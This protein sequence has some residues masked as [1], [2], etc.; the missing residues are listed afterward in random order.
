MATKT[1]NR[2]SKSDNNGNKSRSSSERSA[3]NFGDNN[4]GIL[5]GAAAAGAAL[6]FA[7][8]MGRK[9]LMQ[10]M[11]G[12]AGDWADALA[13]EHKMTL[14]IF[15]KIEATDDSQTTMRST[16]LAKLKYALTKHALEEENVVYPALRQA[17][18]AHDA[19]SLEG[20]HGY[21]KT[22]L[23]ELENMAND[24]PEWL[25]RVRD[26]R[27]MIESHMQMEENEIFPR[28]REQMSDDQNKKLTA[29]MHKEGFK[30]A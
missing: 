9:F 1:D 28:M 6:G 21:V 27:S 4:T 29:M 26:F 17:N 2:R 8:N 22:Y 20:E 18:F 25:A 23:Y 10:G 14:A 19:D 30:F 15:D 7:A 16:L 3:F 5:I 24:S 12:A 11:S 13:A